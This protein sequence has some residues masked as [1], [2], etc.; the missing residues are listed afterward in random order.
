M[1]AKSESGTHEMSASDYLGDQIARAPRFP[2]HALVEVKL[3]KW[4]P[5][6][7]ASA[8]LLDMSVSGFKIQFVGAG[9]PAIGKKLQIYLP[10]AP[11]GITVGGVLE[12]SGVVKWV[13]EANRRVGGMF[14][15]CSDHERL[16]IERIIASVVSKDA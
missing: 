1:A 14:L 3:S 13:D 10:L 15:S 8:V 11:F 12:L 4:N 2:S 9:D 6:S 7:R 16:M 5:F